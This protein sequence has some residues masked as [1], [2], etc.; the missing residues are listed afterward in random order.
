[1]NDR[2]IVKYRYSIVLYPSSPQKL[3]RFREG[4]FVIRVV[5]DVAINDFECTKD[6]SC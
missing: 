4:F 1:V 2:A 6:I 3:L 5:A